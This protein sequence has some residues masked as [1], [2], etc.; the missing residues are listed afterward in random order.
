MLQRLA[1]SFVPAAGHRLPGIARMPNK[2]KLS[3]KFAAPIRSAD[4]PA[5]SEVGSAPV[6]SPVQ[7]RRSSRA[8][9]GL[10]TS[11]ISARSS[12]ITAVL[13]TG[14]AGT[15][16][17]QTVKQEEPVITQP[18]EDTLLA[19]TEQVKPKTGRPR[20]RK[21]AIISDAAVPEDTAAAEFDGAQ[22]ASKSA[23]PQKASKR[24]SKTSLK[25]EPAEPAAPADAS[26]SVDAADAVLNQPGHNAAKSPKQRKPGAKAII[27]TE[28]ATVTKA[29]QAKPGPSVVKPEGDN[30]ILNGTT[31]SAKKSRKQKVPPTQV[32][33]KT[34][35]VTIAEPADDS[36]PAQEADMTSDGSVTPKKP[37]KQRKKAEVS[38]ETL[39]ESV[40]VTPYRQRTV[41]KKWVGA[42]VSMGGGME[43]AVVRAAAIG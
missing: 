41:P 28:T 21:A 10:P 20:K 42:H 12:P 14:P 39:L 5:D 43:R 26:A 27:K 15:L 17:E 34:E 19:V 8:R 40:H 35:T 32:E 7:P 9:S 29:D 3:T 18:A 25:V 23:T 13:D 6:E 37:R 4:L 24:I 1:R 38:V 22:A 36:A 11:A 30:T 33:V 16:A 2:A 31:R